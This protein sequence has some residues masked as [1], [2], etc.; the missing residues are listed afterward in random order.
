MYGSLVL[1]QDKL[2]AAEAENKQLKKAIAE[3]SDYALSQMGEWS[4]VQPPYLPADMEVL[5]DIV[6]MCENAPNTACTGLATPSTQL[7]GSAQRANR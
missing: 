7:A 5:H 3:I 4:C 1:L 2:S 6:E